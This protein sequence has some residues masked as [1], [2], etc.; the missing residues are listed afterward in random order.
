MNYAVD[1][2]T[3]VPS[4]HLGDLIPGMFFWAKYFIGE[5]Q[6][7]IMIGLAVALAFTLLTL[8]ASLFEKKSKSNNDDDDFDY[9]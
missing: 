3:N 6:G 8:I 4:S 2:P 5:V 7:F 1:L 9:Y